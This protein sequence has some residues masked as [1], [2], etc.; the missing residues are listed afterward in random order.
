MH[1]NRVKPNPPSFLSLITI[2]F[3]NLRVL[4]VPDKI[5]SFAENLLINTFY[6]IFGNGK[7]NEKK[8]ILQSAGDF[9]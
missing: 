5:S 9:T 7:N 4:V 8:S 6:K 2:V 3:F 1:R